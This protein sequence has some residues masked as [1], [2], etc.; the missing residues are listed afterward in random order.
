[1]VEHHDLL[2]SRV[3][4]RNGELS[5]AQW[6]RSLRGVRE[7]AWFAWDDPVPFAA[8]C[9]R[10]VLLARQRIGRLGTGFRRLHTRR[11][12]HRGSSPGSQRLVDARFEREAAF[13]D[14][15][16]SDGSVF[17]AVYRHRQALALSWI[18]ALG[19]PERSRVLEVGAGA[20]FTAVQLGARGF[21]VEAIDTTPAM[22][23]ISRRN[24]AE[25]G[26]QAWLRVAMGDAHALPFRAGSFVLVLALG[27]APWLHS[28][29]QAIKE[30]ARVL[31]PGGYL[32]LSADNRARLT[33]FVDPLFSPPLRPVRR[34][35]GAALA[36]A[37]LRRRADG[38]IA[39]ATFHG[40][41][42]FD[43]IVAAAGLER[44]DGS[45]F[46]F[47]PFTLLGR[48]LLPEPLGVRLNDA[49]QRLADRG[50]P[51]IRSTGAQYLLV[52]R[53]PD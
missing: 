14:E 53:K 29:P 27:V 34:A 51:V 39:A 24:A 38:V 6:V 31:Q 48:N 3:Y 5:V 45:T 18:D 33:H 8:M 10:S 43:R 52:A 50:L 47:G 21:R 11:H 42:T 9:W 35:A 12:E 36:V 20:G 23:D 41:R 46:G 25:A 26:M 32:V 40:L 30:M 17:G 13:W 49:L 16:Y 1:M 22:L 15:V 2:A 19:L 28:A 4:R 7:A 37:G 44:V